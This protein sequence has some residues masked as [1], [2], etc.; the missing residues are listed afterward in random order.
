MIKKLQGY[1]YLSIKFKALIGKRYNILNKHKKIIHLFYARFINNLRVSLPHHLVIKH[2]SV[3]L[4][5][6]KNISD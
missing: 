1:I 4:Q 6:N 3:L 5:N 2:L